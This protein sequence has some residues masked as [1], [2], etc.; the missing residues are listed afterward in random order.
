MKLLLNIDGQEP[1]EF[2][3]NK[4]N[5]NIGKSNKN[6]LVLDD[7]LI[8]DIH[9]MFKKVDKGI[10]LED[11]HSTSGTFVNG[12]KIKHHHLMQDRDMITIGKHSLIF[13]NTVSNEKEIFQDEATVMISEDFQKELQKELSKNNALSNQSSN[14]TITQKNT[15][16]LEKI[17]R[18]LGL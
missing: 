11:N 12:I 8:N 7:V 1:Q 5:I 17:K 10:L 2:I 6:D 13:Y 14:N 15:G 4:V 16:F 3:F 9:I 18:I